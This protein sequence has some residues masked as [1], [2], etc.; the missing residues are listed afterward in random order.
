MVIYIC[1]PITGLDFKE[2]EKTFSDAEKLLAWYFDF[3]L[4]NPVIL[5]PMKTPP[6]LTQESYM[7]ISFAQIRA[8]EMLYVLKG[9]EKSDG[10]LAEIAYAK[11]IQRRIVYEQ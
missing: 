6:G 5:N 7:D 10:C 4:K 9:F 3:K 8:S 11:K 2:V 1:G